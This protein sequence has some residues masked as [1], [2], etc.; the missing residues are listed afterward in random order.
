MDKSGHQIHLGDGRRLGYARVG[1]PA[2][3]PVVF[4]HGFPA[5]RLEAGILGPAARQAGASIIA[6][7]R[8]GMG[9]SDF[10]PGRTILDWPDDVRQLADAL[11]LER[12]W[13]VGGSGG[14]PY[15]LACA[16]RLRDRVLGVAIIAG[17]GP[18]TEAALVRRMG[19]LARLGFLLARRTPPLF[20]LGFGSL[21]RLV[22]RHPEINFRLNAAAPPDEE[23][24]A[25]PE[26]HSILTSSVAEALRSGPAGTLREI[27]LL[28]HPW[29]F[30][31]E[32]ISTPAYVWHGCEDRT[33][34]HQYARFLAGKLP[35]SRLTLVEGEGHVSLPVRHGAEIIGTL[36]RRSARSG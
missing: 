8:P 30:E 36:L 35:N 34:P 19:G 33:V 1:D 17:M 13:V 26:V 6:P 11:R 25:R 10:Q 31:L 4:Q 21:A 15:A 14:C 28:A 23:V 3:L 27:E 7:D 16:H 12:F 18:A 29:G 5:S 32:E 9:L 24:M 22:A 20:R 2:G